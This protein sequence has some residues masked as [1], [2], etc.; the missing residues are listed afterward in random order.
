[1]DGAEKSWEDYDHCG[2]LLLEQRRSRIEGALKIKWNGAEEI[3]RSELAGRR[4]L[5]SKKKVALSLTLHFSHSE[6]H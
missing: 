1:M 6:F 5:F 4:F 2:L 3:F